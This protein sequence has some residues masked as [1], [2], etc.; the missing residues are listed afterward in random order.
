LVNEKLSK[1]EQMKAQAH[2][3]EEHQSPTFIQFVGMGMKPPC[4]DPS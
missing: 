4:F 1:V 2:N 3:A